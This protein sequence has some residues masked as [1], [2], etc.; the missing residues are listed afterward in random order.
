MATAGG[1]ASKAWRT[2]ASATRTAPS[3]SRT[4][5]LGARG[6]GSGGRQEVIDAF[7]MLLY[8]HADLVI[9]TSGEMRLSNF[10]LWQS[11]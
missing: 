1:R 5:S 9:R 4:C 3:T 6:P 2:R 11:A 10:L 7:R 8:E